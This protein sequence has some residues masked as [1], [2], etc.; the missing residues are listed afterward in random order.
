[1]KYGEKYGDDGLWEGA[2]RVFD[3][4]KVMN[5]S[6]NAQTIGE[7]HHCRGK[8]SNFENCKLPTCNNLMLVCQK[9]RENE[10][11]L[12]CSSACAKKQASAV[13]KI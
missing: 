5:F 11:K 12:F 3:G 2:L 7:C 6:E 10:D 9:C 4:R 1:M 8:T 13:T